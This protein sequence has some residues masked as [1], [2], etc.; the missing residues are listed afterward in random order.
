MRGGIE[1][2]RRERK[3]VQQEKEDEH[4]RNME[5]FR[6]MVEQAKREGRERRD[7]QEHDRYSSETDPVVVCSTKRKT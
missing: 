5:A 7:M 6:K 1:E 4:K 2:E 3:K